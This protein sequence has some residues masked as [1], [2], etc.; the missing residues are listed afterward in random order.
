MMSKPLDSQ[1]VQ[2]GC[3]SMKKLSRGISA[4]MTP[5]A[6]LERLQIMSD[7]SRWCQE[8]GQAQWIGKANDVVSD[9]SKQKSL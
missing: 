6:I 4:C 3:D 9:T 5:E 8:L 2:T 1:S 7:L